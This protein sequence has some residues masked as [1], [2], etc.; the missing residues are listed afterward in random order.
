MMLTGIAASLADPTTRALLAIPGDAQV[1]LA[2]DTAPSASGYNVKQATSAS[3]PMTAIET[4]IAPAS[5]V[6]TNLKNG[7]AYFFA[8]S[9][10][11]GEFESDNTPR[12][13]ATPSA[14]FL[15]VLPAGA[16]LEKL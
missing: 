14:P 2:W 6:V 3:G 8:V 15:D 16:K 7:T 5:L 13:R 10:V 1:T 12:L 4:N 9:A 11:A